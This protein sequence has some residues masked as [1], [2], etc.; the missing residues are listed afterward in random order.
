MANYPYTDCVGATVTFSSPSSQKKKRIHSNI[1]RECSGECLMSIAEEQVERIADA[2]TDNKHEDAKVELKHKSLADGRC[3]VHIKW[4]DNSRTLHGVK[5]VKLQ[6][7]NSRVYCRLYVDDTP[8]NTIGK[9][10]ELF[11]NFRLALTDTVEKT[12]KIV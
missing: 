12:M 6:G 7:S 5:M 1:I 9:F 10:N 2:L 11:S 8:E 4:G 3:Y